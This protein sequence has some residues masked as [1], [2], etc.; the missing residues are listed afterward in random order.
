MPDRHDMADDPETYHDVESDE[1]AADA[2]GPRPSLARILG[3]MFFLAIVL[4]TARQARQPDSQPGDVQPAGSPTV[5]AEID[6]PAQYAW[7]TAKE[8][9]SYQPLIDRFP[10][11]QG[12]R[13]VQAAVGSF[14][15]WLRFLPVL[16]EGT[17][18]KTAARE[19]L[20]PADHPSLA[21]VIA[22]QPQTPKTLTASNVLVRLRAEYLWAVDRA[23]QAAFHFASGHLSPWREWAEG[24]RPT[25]RGRE[26]SLSKGAPADSSRANFCGYLEGVFK[27]GNFD[28]LW[29]DTDKA[30]DAAVEGGDV[31]LRRGRTGHAV[32]VLDVATDPQ[33]HVDVLLGQGGS[34]PQTF[35][36]LRG[37]DG[38]P[39]FPL[40][41]TAP[42]DVGPKGQFQLTDLRHWKSG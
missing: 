4:M 41:R 10:P 34:P 30:T 12:F 40:S 31:F 22:L 14:A 13:R 3:A 9:K 36:V 27:Y 28:S 35:H 21:A 8:R 20:L 24:Y 18:V 37:K 1:E 6:R 32:M 5:R 19:I 39:W 2:P 29:H 33:G 7:L 42:I 38:S 15:D 23:D 11:P 25:V 17:P 16:P 26:V